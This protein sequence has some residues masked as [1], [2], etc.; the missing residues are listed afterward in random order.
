MELVGT[1]FRL[2]T[3]QYATNLPSFG[4]PISTSMSTVLKLIE[5]TPQFVSV[6][7][8][9]TDDVVATYAWFT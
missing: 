5:Q 7:V 8:N 9:V 6:S 3:P 2:A 4:M 1:Q